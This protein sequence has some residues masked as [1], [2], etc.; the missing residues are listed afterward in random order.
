MN[1]T[2]EQ[3]IAYLRMSLNLDGANVNS[4]PAYNLSDDDLWMIL[5]MATTNH[6]PL[7]TIDSL[8]QNELHFAILLARREVYYR[9]ASTSAP[10]YPLEAEGA[11]LR[12]DYRF[13]HYYKLIQLVTSQYESAWAD[14]DSKVN[15]V[16]NTYEVLLASKHL[17]ARNYR[18]ATAPKVEVEVAKIEQD[19]VGIK[20]TKPTSGV[21]RKYEVYIGTTDLIDEFTDEISSEAKKLVCERDIHNT[22]LKIVNLEPDTEYHVLVMCYDIN[23]LFGATEVTFTTKG[24]VHPDIDPLTVE[25]E[26]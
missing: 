22:K 24:L 25:M 6:N 18:L 7:Y 21:F 1:F 16:I 10:F 15:S 14:F 12:K 17:S 19:W 13:D 9:L 20:W 5:C 8:P 11:S 4:D 26:G 3:L 2:K 23:G